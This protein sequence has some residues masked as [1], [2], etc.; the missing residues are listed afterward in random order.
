MLED[1][2]RW[3]VKR[4]DDFSCKHVRIHCLRSGYAAVPRN[5][6][7]KKCNAAGWVAEDALKLQLLADSPPKR[8]KQ[9]KYN[10]AQDEN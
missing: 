4:S 10:V 1:G 3:H 8:R 7:R 5:S 9:E 2:E 6:V